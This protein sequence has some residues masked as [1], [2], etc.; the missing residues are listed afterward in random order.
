MIDQNTFFIVMDSSVVVKPNLLRIT[1][2]F[3]KRFYSKKIIFREKTE[4]SFRE[5]RETVI[6]AGVHYCTR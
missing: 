1:K 3:K 5:K 2:V 6:K 4:S